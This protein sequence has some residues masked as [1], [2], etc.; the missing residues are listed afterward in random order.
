MK[1]NQSVFISDNFV[2]CLTIEVECIRLYYFFVFSSRFCTLLY[3]NKYMMY[4]RDVFRKYILIK[5][6]VEKKPVSNACDE[7]IKTMRGMCVASLKQKQK[8]K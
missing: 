1:K 7:K 6:L 8:Y 4:T 3:N 2:K 5:P